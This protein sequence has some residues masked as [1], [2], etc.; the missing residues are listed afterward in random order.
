MNRRQINALLPS[1]RIIFDIKT[2]ATRDA[3]ADVF[4]GWNYNETHFNAFQW[5]GIKD[6]FAT[7]LLRRLASLSSGRNSV[8]LRTC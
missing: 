1:Y 5:R 3:V 8:I 2:Q 6:P 7:Y 4:W